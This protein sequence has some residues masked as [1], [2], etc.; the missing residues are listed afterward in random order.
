MAVV[1]R[2]VA[3]LGAGWSKALL[4]YA[5][6]V[7]HLD[8]KPITD[9]TS[10]KFLAAMHGF[11]RDYW[12][13]AGILKAGDAIPE[14]LEDGSYGD[15]CQHGSWYF[16][17][18]HRGYLAA[19]EAIVAATVKQLTGDDWALPYWNYLDAANPQARAIPAAFLAP[20]MP[21]GSPNPLRR[22]PRQLAGPLPAAPAN[23][24]GLDAMAETNFQVGAIGSI[25]FGGGITAFERGGDGAGALEFNPHN[26]VHGML[27]GFMGNPYFAALD[28]IFWLHHCNI[29]RLWEA[30]MRTAGRT[31]TRDP[32][33]LDGPPDRHFLMP[34]VDGA[35]PGIRF[36]ARDT[37]KGAALHPSYDDLTKGT[38]VTP[39]EAPMG[40]IAMGPPEQQAVELIGSNA[41][42]VVI[43]SAGAETRVALDSAATHAA[44]ASMGATVPGT[45]V[46]R[47][48]LKLDAIRGA[49]PTAILDVYINLPAGETAASRPDL[50]AGS[51]YLFGLERASRVDGGHA[52]NGLGFALDITDLASKLGGEDGFDTAA[53]DVAL[54]P[55]EGSSDAAPVTIGKVSLL[56][57]SGV[58]PAA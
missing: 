55:V 36:S 31:M 10:W 35:E 16:L 9:R 28:P 32:R 47:L 11:D 8:A 34:S 13:Q 44:V 57:R 39:A 14:N 27:G 49:A 21:D 23:V 29:D 46:S 20:A 43:G 5:L 30:W 2:D 37:L 50:R 26:V 56:K 17:P 48:Y 42:A 1:R 41:G 22:Y 3:T 15:Q 51:L 7:R 24:F 33:W 40:H 18:W 52:G 4:N 54:V 25:G 45:P 12:R 6:A 53:L 58:V 19:F 38:G